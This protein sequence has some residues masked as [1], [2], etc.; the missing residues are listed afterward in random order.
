MGVAID[1]LT[2]RSPSA[3]TVHRTHENLEANHITT[4]VKAYVLLLS[5]RV[6]TAARNEAT[7]LGPRLIYISCVKVV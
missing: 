1:T 5:C 7:T 4:A 2:K 3:F 6:A